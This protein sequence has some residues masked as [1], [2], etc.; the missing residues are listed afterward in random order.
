MKPQE[1]R[2]VEP[3]MNAFESIITSRL[4]DFVR[5][6][7]PTFLRSKAR[8]DP[9]EFTDGVYKVLSAIGV[10]SRETSCLLTN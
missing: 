8:E 6:N 3:R 10:N 2:A 4:S 9:K 1:N 7:P 5:T